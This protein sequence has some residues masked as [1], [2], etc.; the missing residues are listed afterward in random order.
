M[1]RRHLEPLRLGL[2]GLLAGCQAPACS[3][4]TARRRSC[5]PTGAGDRHGACHRDGRAGRS[6]GR[7]AGPRPRALIL[8]LLPGVAPD[9]FM[10]GARLAGLTA[11]NGF[12]LGNR[13]VVV[14]LLPKGEEAVAAR[15]RLAG[16][17]GLARVDLDSVM[18]AH[19]APAAQFYPQQWSLHPKYA[20]VE[21]AWDRVASE[22]LAVDKVVV[23]DVDTGV[24]S[25][26]TFTANDGLPEPR[27]RRARARY[28]ARPR[29]RPATT[30]KRA[31]RSSVIA[32]VMAPSPP[33]SSP[34]TR[35]RATS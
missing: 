3:S 32:S 1:R 31:R 8:S 7:G 14:V 28:S 29:T 34:R 9:A 6:P 35:P 26:A 12:T 24:E 17:P 13:A 10:A 20:N 30:T 15:A 23:A 21:A 22:H 19:A 2:V 18:Q 5:A 33:A 16:L 25:T 4:R 11:V 27:R